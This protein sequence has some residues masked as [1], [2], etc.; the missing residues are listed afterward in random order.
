MRQVDKEKAG[1]SERKEAAA[2]P[3]M[4]LERWGGEK[5]EGGREGGMRG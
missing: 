3:G 1:R 5:E 2:R 4:E